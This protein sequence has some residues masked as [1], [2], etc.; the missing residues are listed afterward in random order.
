M[1][2]ISIDFPLI[3]DWETATLY[4]FGNLQALIPFCLDESFPQNELFLLRFCEIKTI[5]SRN[6]VLPLEP[7]FT[8]GASNVH[9]TFL[10]SNLYAA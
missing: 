10:S 2:S 8:I 5:V 3:S 6:V 9:N 1:G 4:N 7:W